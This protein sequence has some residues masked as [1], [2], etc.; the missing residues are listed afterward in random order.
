M[1]RLPLPQFNVI[2]PPRSV[3]MLS[4][5]LTGCRS[6][7]VPVDRPLHLHHTFNNNNHHNMLY[8]TNTNPYSSSLLY[9]NIYSTRLDSLSITGNPPLHLARLPGLPA[10][11]PT[12]LTQYRQLTE[13]LLILPLLVRIWLAN[14]SIHNHLWHLHRLCSSR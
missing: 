2:L 10:F 12:L 8:L 6:R 7:V 11:L 13:Y 14:H 4:P 1:Y 3:C 9:T 5:R